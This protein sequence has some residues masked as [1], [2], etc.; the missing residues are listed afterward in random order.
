MPRRERPL[1]A[2][3]PA[4]L[5]IA[6]ALSPALGGRLALRAFFRTSPRMRVR[7]AEAA[8]HE[9]TRQERLRVNGKP[10]VAYRWGG[11]QAPAVLLLHGWGG[12]ATQF[13][14]LV[15]ELVAEGLSVVAFDAPAHGASG[16]R[17]T[18]IRDWLEAIRQLDPGPG[19]V[20]VV[21]HSFGGLAALTAVRDGLRTGAVAVIASAA[22]PATFRRVFADGVGLDPATRERFDARFRARL[23]VDADEETRRYDAVADPLPDGVRLLVAHD[24]R[25]RLMPDADALRLHAAHGAR[26]TLLRTEGLGHA[27]ILGDDRVLDALVALATGAVA[28]EEDAGRPVRLGR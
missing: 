24:R 21:G 3:A 6:G 1:R 8:T 9:S 4:L 5:R 26:S 22:S 11:E 20:A 17:R 18:D 28:G 16:G 27:R 25:D 23:G 10:V 14:P 12:R 19:F 7:D 15:R 2:A 13:A